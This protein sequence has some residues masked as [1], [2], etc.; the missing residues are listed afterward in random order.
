MSDLQPMSGK[1]SFQLALMIMGIVGA[2]ASGI[3]TLYKVMW[4]TVENIDA[5][6]VFIA[7]LYV[8]FFAVIMPSAE[9]GMMEHNE[10]VKF[11]LSYVGRAF[12]YLFMGGL[13]LGEE[14]ASCIIGVFM[15]VLSIMNIVGQVIANKS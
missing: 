14:V 5:A 7:R 15:I 2:A 12:L 8:T 4:Y 13:L 9:L 3:M 6:R 1:N 10:M 11:L